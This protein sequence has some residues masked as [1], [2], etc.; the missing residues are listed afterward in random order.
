MLRCASACRCRYLLVL[1][2]LLQGPQVALKADTNARLPAAAPH[3]MTRY[4]TA[5]TSDVEHVSL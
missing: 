4:A 3:R 1:Q 2:R 5:K